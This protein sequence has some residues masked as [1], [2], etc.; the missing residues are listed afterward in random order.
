LRGILLIMLALAL[1]SCVQEPPADTINHVIIT[2]DVPGPKPRRISVPDGQ[3]ATDFCPVSHMITHTPIHLPVIND[4]APPAVQP[5]NND[6][7]GHPP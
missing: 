2:C 5:E 7:P 1:A 3:K 4:A 6:I